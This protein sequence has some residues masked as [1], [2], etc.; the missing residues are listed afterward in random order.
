MAFGYTPAFPWKPHSST[1]CDNDDV[2]TLCPIHAASCYRWKMEENLHLYVLILNLKYISLQFSILSFQVF[3]YQSSFFFLC[4]WSATASERTAIGF[5][6]D[7][8]WYL[9]VGSVLVGWRCRTRENE[10]HFRILKMVPSE[11]PRKAQQQIVP[12]RRF[13][14]KCRSRR[15]SFLISLNLCGFSIGTGKNVQ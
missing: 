6:W 2:S 8:H 10:L 3:L 11:Q 13:W 4:I 9:L 12:Y 7:I 14:I 1:P 15:E 5:L